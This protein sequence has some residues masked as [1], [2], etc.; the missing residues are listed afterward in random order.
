[1]PDLPRLGRGELA[2]IAALCRRG[3][4]DAPTED[5]LAASLFTPGFEVTARGDPER[6]VVATCVRDGQAY[7]RLLVVDPAARG[8]GMGRSLLRAA[9]DDLASAPTITVGA[10][11]PDHLF[12]GVETTQ[13]ELLCLLER[14]H[15]ARGEA[16]YNL[17]IHLDRLPPAPSTSDAAV[18]DADARDEV[19]RWVSAHWA[20]WRTEVL[21]CLDRH[22]LMV[23]R[24]DDGIA[25]VCCWD[26]ARAGWVGP[27]A[28]RPAL[29]G[30]GRG[31]SVL[32]GALAE[33]RA[34]GRRQAEIGWVGPILPY[35]R[36]IP[37]TINRVFF[38]YRKTRP[39]R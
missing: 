19:D 8:Q 26:G 29:I 28:V 31:R 13:V 25:A 7:I 9:E 30:R 33:M 35:A 37:A 11:A 39:A 21:R 15:Y 32:L 18:A 27:V 10:D 22:R 4:P 14:E 23:S 3:T 20:H 38:V 24:D 34:A 1:V 6:G 12:P 16:N 17:L 5:D 36:T 2:A